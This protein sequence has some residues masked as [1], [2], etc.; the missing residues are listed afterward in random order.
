MSTG[1]SQAGVGM[2]LKDLHRG[3]N[4]TGGTPLVRTVSKGGPA[5]FDPTA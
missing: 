3:A 2:M 1:R 4:G 5:Q